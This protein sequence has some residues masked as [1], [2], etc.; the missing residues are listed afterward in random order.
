L[1]SLRQTDSSPPHARTHTHTHTRTPYHVGHCY[2]NVIV[3]QRCATVN[4]VPNAVQQRVSQMETKDSHCCATVDPPPR[5]SLFLPC[6]EKKRDRRALVCKSCFAHAKS[7]GPPD[8]LQDLWNSCVFINVTYSHTCSNEI[9]FFRLKPFIFLRIVTSTYYRGVDVHAVTGDDIVCGNIRPS[10]VLTTALPSLYNYN[11]LSRFICVSAF[12][13]FIRRVSLRNKS[14]E[15][16][17]SRHWRIAVP[18]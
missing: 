18:S 10:F 17:L 6:R 4:S 3:A 14:A 7:W 12:S 9:S 15:K 2:T 11:S 13:A 8:Y 5:W 16:L 1:F